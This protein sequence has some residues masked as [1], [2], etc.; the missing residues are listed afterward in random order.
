MNVRPPD[1]LISDLRT[2]FKLG[3]TSLQQV[4]ESLS[5]AEAFR[6]ESLID[7]ASDVIGPDA[8]KLLIKLLLSIQGTV[9]RFGAEVSD[10][11][12][13]LKDS[14]DE[15][16]DEHEP[17]KAEFD[18]LS[19]L[20][21]TNAIRRAA[22]AIELSYDYANLLRNARIITDLR[23]LFDDD[24]T[25]IEGSIVSYTLRLHYDSADGE[26][27]VSLALDQR[28]IKN[29]KDQCERA[30]LKATLAVASVKFPTNIVGDSKT[31]K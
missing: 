11:I 13:S 20:L 24:V 22:K 10:I 31:G 26:H 9:R 2:C 23:P 4:A 7:V 29:L 12:D 25:K 8:A 15:A 21:S 19:R 3:S 30:L 28:D 17:F 16:G 27:D 18:A 5:R 14:L 6:T 1:G